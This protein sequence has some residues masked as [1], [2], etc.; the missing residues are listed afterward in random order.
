MLRTDYKEDLDLFKKQESALNNLR[1]HIQ[2]AVSR[3]YLI[4]TFCCDTPYDMLVSL[5][6]RVAPTDDAQKLQFATQYVKLKMG[7]QNQNIEIW[8]Q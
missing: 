6:Q 5:K 2:E 8:L 4:Y 7:P 1:C 3:N